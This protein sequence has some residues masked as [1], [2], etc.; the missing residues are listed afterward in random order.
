KHR[1]QQREADQESAA[2][3]R[4]ARFDRPEE[5]AVRDGRADRVADA[6]RARGRA[7]RAASSADLARAGLALRR[8]RVRLVGRRRGR[9]GGA[10]PAREPRPYTR[11]LHVEDDLG[12]VLEILEIGL[13]HLRREFLVLDDGIELAIAEPARD[14]Q[15]RRAD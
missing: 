8:L 10:A 9:L 5:P 11:A 1:E 15:V 13:L 12:G 4:E 2:E 3:G 6:D 7:A 14:V